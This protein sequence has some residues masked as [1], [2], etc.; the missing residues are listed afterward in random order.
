MTLK[1]MMSKGISCPL[2]PSR[3]FSTRKPIPRF[4]IP[5]VDAMEYT[6]KSYDVDP[7]ILG[8]LIG[9]GSLTGNV[10]IFSNPDVDS[11]IASERLC[12]E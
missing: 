10:A 12:L 4:E 11:Q 6:E 3:Q 1:E 2:S 9:D 8:V 5:V 7:Y